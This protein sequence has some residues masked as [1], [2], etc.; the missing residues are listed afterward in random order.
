MTALTK[1]RR[2]TAV[3]LPYTPCH[4]LT[5]YNPYRICTQNYMFHSRLTLILEMRFAHGVDFKAKW[6]SFEAGRCTQN[7]A[8]MC[9]CAPPF[10]SSQDTVASTCSVRG[11]IPFHNLRTR[12]GERGSCR[13]AWAKGTL[14]DITHDHA[15]HTQ[16]S[17][18]EVGFPSSLAAY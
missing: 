3:I 12:N 18:R 17:F 1:H 10:T 15:F 11:K 2:W 5:L 9:L 14:E 13:K 16:R 7:A 8:W 6:S 4:S